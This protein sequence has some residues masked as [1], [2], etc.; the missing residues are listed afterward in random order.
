MHDG[1]LFVLIQTGS[2]YNDVFI[3]VVVIQRTAYDVSKVGTQVVFYLSRI[4]RRYFETIMICFSDFKSVRLL[5]F[6]YTDTVRALDLVNFTYAAQ[7]Q[8]EKIYF[9]E[10]LYVDKK[11]QIYWQYEF[12]SVFNI[13]SCFIKTQSLKYSQSRQQF[14]LLCE[15]K[16]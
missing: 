14:F 9:K 4:P 7:Q 11:I 3:T 13:Q 12:C 2:S 6:F 10:L 5:W 16:L 1:R 15:F 8:C